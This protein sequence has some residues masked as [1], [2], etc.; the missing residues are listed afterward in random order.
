MKYQFHSLFWYLIDLL[1]PP[2]CGGCQVAGVR[3]CEN[4]QQV[5]VK[6][7]PPICKICGQVTANNPICPRCIAIPPHYEAVRAWAEYDGPIRNAILDLKFRKNIGLGASLAQHLID[8]FKQYNW[9]ID[10][11]LPVPLG[12]QRLK[13]RGYNQAALLAQPLAFELQ[14]PY[15]TRILNR[16]RETK[17][18]TELSFAER[19]ENVKD[20]FLATN[21]E[22]PDKR[23]LLIDDVTT[24]GSTMNACANALMKAGS[25]AVYGLTLARPVLDS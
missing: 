16:V 14:L 19:L 24:S 12:K 1:F 8:L 21:D 13:Q 2:S 20:A 18:Q 5:T 23:I 6:I 3:W 25:K 15:N 17:S 10:I 22:I 11:V 7:V 4:C 9:P